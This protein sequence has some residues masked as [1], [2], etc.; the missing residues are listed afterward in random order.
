MHYMRSLSEAWASSIW[1]LRASSLARSSGPAASLQFPA[2][3]SRLRSGGYGGMVNIVPVPEV[4]RDYAVYIRQVE[5]RI[6]W[7]FFLL[8]TPRSVEM[9][10]CHE[11][12]V[13]PCC[14][15]ASADGQARV[16]PG[17]RCRSDAAFC[18]MLNPPRFRP[19]CGCA[20]RS[21]GTPGHVRSFPPRSPG[22]PGLPTFQQTSTSARCAP[23]P[24]RRHPDGYVAKRSAHYVS[25]IGL[26]EFQ[27]VLY[28]WLA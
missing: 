1:A 15:R 4:I 6:P 20:S 14:G 7:G 11:S 23:R 26:P 5:G 13:L 28:P 3:I 24:S 18:R 12:G 21:G 2:A 17:R 10:S 19:L 9:S 22:A 27:S 25:R 8:C 16:H